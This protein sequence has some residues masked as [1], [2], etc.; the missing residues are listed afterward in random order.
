MFIRCNYVPPGYL[1]GK[2]FP[3]LT[4][5]QA[6]LSKKP[7][8]G[9][10]HPRLE[11]KIFLRHGRKSKYFSDAAIALSADFSV[12]VWWW[13]GDRQADTAAQCP[14]VFKL[15]ADTRNCCSA[16]IVNNFI[17]QILYFSLPWLM[18][19]RLTCFLCGCS[20]T[21]Q[22][23]PTLILSPLF[24]CIPQLCCQLYICVKTD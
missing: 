16:D 24:R 3:V 12:C 20:P 22:G 11:I 8:S 21:A 5:C 14:V 4:L 17:F 18:R 7:F 23:E 13:G 9:V 2:L 15:C 19:I 10:K 6:G 1:L